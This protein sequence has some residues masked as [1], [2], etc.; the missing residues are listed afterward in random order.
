ME[1]SDI[2]EM[3]QSMRTFLETCWSRRREEL[4]QQQD[5]ER[6]PSDRMCRYSALFCAHVLSRSTG[7]AWTM[8]GGAPMAETDLR[9]IKGMQNGGMQDTD[10][11]WRGH[12]WC[13]DADHIVD[14]AAD[15]FGWQPVLVVPANDARYREGYLARAL[16]RHARQVA[17]W[18][19]DWTV[20]WQ[21]SLALPHAGIGR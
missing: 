19:Q 12:Y 4:F 9:D 3:A 5:V 15:Q 20:L 14:L 18:V 21:E 8:R 2:I 7:K 13:T 11:I 16:G 10:G 1:R 17:P 6:C